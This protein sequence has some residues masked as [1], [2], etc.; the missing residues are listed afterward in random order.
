MRYPYSQISGS[1]RNPGLESHACRSNEPVMGFRVWDSGLGH[2]RAC[3]VLFV[4][5]LVLLLLFVIIAV[6]TTAAAVGS[7]RALFRRPVDYILTL[8]DKLPAV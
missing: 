4:L 3:S 7:S 1:A 2:R 5:L 6:A 8:F